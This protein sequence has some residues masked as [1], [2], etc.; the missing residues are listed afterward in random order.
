MPFSRPSIADQWNDDDGAYRREGRRVEGDV[1]LADCKMTEHHLE[2]GARV[3]VFGQFSES[4]RAIVANPNNWSKITRVMK[5][6]PD[7]IARQLRRSVVRRTVGAL[8]FGG[9]AA[10]VIAAFV[11]DVFQ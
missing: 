1:K 5:G 6:D 2:R 9:I 11:A 8:I 7:A 4:K 10:G 3:C